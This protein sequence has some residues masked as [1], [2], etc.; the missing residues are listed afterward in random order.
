MWIWHWLFNMNLEYPESN[1]K[2]VSLRDQNKWC[3][4]NSGSGEMLTCKRSTKWIIK[5]CRAVGR[6]AF[7]WR[8]YIFD[9]PLTGTDKHKHKHTY[10]ANKHSCHNYICLLAIFWNC[11]SNI[12]ADEICHRAY[13]HILQVYTLLIILKHCISY[14]SVHTNDTELT[15]QVG[16]ANKQFRL[17]RTV[18]D[19]VC[20]CSNDWTRK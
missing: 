8:F 3:K 14:T 5:W 10:I 6:N 19:G 11:G 15:Q 7:A 20:F 9:I 2:Q 13:V 4:T 17:Q 16:V 12:R 1:H 18:F